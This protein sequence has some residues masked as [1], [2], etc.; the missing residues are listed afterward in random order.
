M[1]DDWKI[2]A[3]AT[4]RT[5]VGAAGLAVFI[6]ALGP[7][8]ALDLR[9]FLHG[10]LFSLLSAGYSAADHYYA[11]AKYH[12]AA[13]LDPDAI[14]KTVSRNGHPYCLV[15]R[16]FAFDAD[17]KLPND[18]NPF[19]GFP[20]GFGM[21]IIDAQE[22]LMRAA[23]PKWRFF[24]WGGR[25]GAVRPVR[26]VAS[27]EWLSDVKIAILRAGVVF[28]IPGTS[29]SLLL[30]I[31]FALAER[32]HHVVFVFPPI[33]QNP[34]LYRALNSNP[35]LASLAQRV[36]PAGGLLLPFQPTERESL[37]IATYPINQQQL[38]RVLEARSR[39]TA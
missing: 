39:A 2:T 12:W 34:Q 33:A 36:P 30:E 5:L 11:Q 10:V 27:E 6:S 22:W 7:G 31:E 3:L 20:V 18:F 23:G 35:L 32:P 16:S 17:V 37:D 25:T 15:L 24:S 8:A 21:P 13:D 1:V 14:V 19:F 28:I 9:L 38:R 4:L 26:V 29:P